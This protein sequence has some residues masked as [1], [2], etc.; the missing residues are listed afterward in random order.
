MWPQLVDPVDRESV[1]LIARSVLTARWPA[2]RWV[3]IGQRIRGAIAFS[4]VDELPVCSQRDVVQ[5]VEPH[6]SMGIAIDDHGVRSVWVS[7]CAGRGNDTLPDG[8][9]T[10]GHLT[11]PVIASSCERRCE[12]RR[13]EPDAW[14]GAEKMIQLHRRKRNDGGRAGFPRG[15]GR[16]TG[17]MSIQSKRCHYQRHCDQH[18]AKGDGSPSSAEH[19]GAAYGVF[20]PPIGPDGS[21]QC[22]NEPDDVLVERQARLPVG[23][24]GDDQQ[25]PVPHVQRIGKP[26]HPTKRPEAQ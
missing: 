8:G 11:S 14:S 20:H 19:A 1:P 21:N 17:L 23:L 5:R 4:K 16:F 7:G 2:A 24:G 26:S 15:G 12:V 10:W 3:R 18:E 25:G 22:R 13:K 6:C 9:K